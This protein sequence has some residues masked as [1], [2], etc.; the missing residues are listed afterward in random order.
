LVTELKRQA[1]KMMHHDAI[2][3]TSLIYII[4][5]ETLGLHQTIDRNAENLQDMF[6]HKALFEKGIR[7]DELTLCIPRINERNLCLDPLKARR[8]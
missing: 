6:T 2:T 8:T 1:A 3:G 5:N 4:Y 7:L